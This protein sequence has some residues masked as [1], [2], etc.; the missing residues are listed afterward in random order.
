LISALAPLDRKLAQSVAA[1]YVA[2]LRE[3]DFRRGQAFGAPWE[4]FG[5]DGANRQNAVYLA[6]IALPYAI[7]RDLR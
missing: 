4:C 5:R 7:L 2:D 3:Q 1:E 6:S